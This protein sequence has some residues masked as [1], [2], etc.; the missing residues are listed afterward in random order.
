MKRSTARRLRILT[1]HVHGNYLYYLSQVPHDFYLVTRPPD[2]SGRVPPGYAG[3][4]GAL[5]WGD[6]VHEVP[7]DA[8]AGERFDAVLFQSR[9]HWEQDRLTV[10]S[11]AQRA[12]PTIYLE[13][14]PPQEH[15]TNT[16][17]WVQDPNVLLVHVTPFNALM[18]DS[19]ITPTRVIEHGV[20]LP[21]PARYSGD[22]A[23]GI[24]VVN[25]LARRGRR[26]GADVFDTLRRQVP[27]DLVGMGAEDAGG[28][29]EVGNLHLPAF[30]ARYR[31]FFNP[32][33]YTSLGLAVVEAMTIGMPI[34]GLATTEMSTVIDSGHNGYVDTRLDALADAMHTLLHDPALARRWG[35]AARD[36]ARQR[37]GIE[38]FVADWLDALDAVM[39]NRQE[40]A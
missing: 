15:P 34:V 33:R 24:V 2:A 8:V 26:L 20:H 32:I 19:G 6:N 4:V 7:F 38:R 28:I 36:T 12:L 3:K 31:F 23:R 37:F 27:L 10:L 9:A 39:A 14:D 16:R 1:W 25:H 21:V 13:H 30:C 17:H 11:P 29:G 35:D 18:W 22:L 5:P 40:A